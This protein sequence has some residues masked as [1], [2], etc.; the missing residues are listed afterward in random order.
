MEKAVRIMQNFQGDGGIYR[1]QEKR[2]TRKGLEHYRKASQQYQR[3]TPSP[4][5]AC[6]YNLGALPRPRTRRGAAGGG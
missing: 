3:P 6:A 4:R 1:K 2:G 5:K